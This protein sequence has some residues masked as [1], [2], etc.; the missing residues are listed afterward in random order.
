MIFMA[1][2]VSGCSARNAAMAFGSGLPVS[3]DGLDASS[4]S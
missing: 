1:F 3:G 2:A 4:R